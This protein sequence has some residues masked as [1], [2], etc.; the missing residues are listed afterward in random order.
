MRRT[1]INLILP[2]VLSIKYAVKPFHIGLNVEQGRTVEH[3]RSVHFQYIILAAKQPD[4]TK[5]DRIGP[6]GRPRG[7]YAPFSGFQK[8]FYPHSCL[9]G[10]VKMVYKVDV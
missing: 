1:L 7:K 4:N 8:G 3:V 9:I 6:A 5:S 2:S 10:R